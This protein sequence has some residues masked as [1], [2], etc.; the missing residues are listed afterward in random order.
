[1]ASFDVKLAR[2]TGIYFIIERLYSRD[3]IMPSVG[4][5]GPS[6]NQVHRTIIQ[7][8]R[9]QEIYMDGAQ[10]VPKDISLWQQIKYLTGTKVT[11]KDTEVLIY[12]LEFMGSIMGT[13]PLP[14]FENNS[15]PR[16]LTSEHIFSLP[17]IMSY[18]RDPIP[19]VLLYGR[20][21]VTFFMDN[22]GR[23]NPTAIAKYNKNIKDLAMIND[24]V[25]AAS[26]MKNILSPGVK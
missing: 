24:Q 8:R 15:I 25:Q 18:G 26:I 12:T 3:G 1:M 5:V 7:L 22:G 4:E 6:L 23:G 11:T 19:D 13:T 20:S 14:G 17:S 21:N 16:F 9:K 10:I 2:P